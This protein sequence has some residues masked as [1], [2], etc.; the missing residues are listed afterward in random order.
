MRKV[1]I[2]IS[3]LM[4]SSMLPLSFENVDSIGPRQPAGIL[5]YVVWAGNGTGIPNLPVTLTNLNT[6]EYA[7]TTTNATGFFIS[8]LFAYDGENFYGNATYEGTTGD[9]TITVDLTLTSQWMNIS[10]NVSNGQTPVCFWTYTPHEPCAGDTVSFTDSSSDPDG[11]IV[12]WYWNFG[13]GEHGFSKHTTHSFSEVGS[14]YVTLTV[15]DNDGNTAWKR[16]Q[17]DVIDCGGPPDGDE[18]DEDIIFI[19]PIP[20][21]LYPNRPYTVPDMYHML[22]IDRMHNGKGVK[23]AVIDTGVAF[24]T[25]DKINLSEV[26][27][28]AHPSMP[29]INDNVGHGTWCN[30]AV[31]YGLQNLT[32]RGTQYSIKIIDENTCDVSVL[33][34]ALSLAKRLDVDVISISLGGRGGTISDVVSSKILEMRKAGIIVVCAAGND[35]P[36]SG[37][38]NTPGISG[39]AITVGSVD[40]QFTLDI[41]GDD[42]ISPWSSRGPVAG[43]GECKPDCVAGG[44]SI[45]GPYGNTERVVS[46]TSMATPCIAGGVAVVYSQHEFLYD[47]LKTLYFPYKQIVPNIFEKGLEK[48]CY[49]KGDPYAY[50]YGIPNFEKMS[51]YCSWM[52]FLF[53]ILW[54]IIVSIIV[55]IVTLVIYK[56]IKNKNP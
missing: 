14:Y 51:G 18:D 44:E 9:V 35:G 42:T 43:L 17:I 16:K 5:G 47:T 28:Y 56:K 49:D 21:P 22:K 7:N 37:T 12:W 55:V 25:Y 20:E 54:I 36:I 50:G 13:D 45:I 30:Y 29:T 40:P 32:S 27:A 19:P 34:D 53:T 24:V 48:H 31:A 46:G 15:T 1:A 10:I 52:A 6:G 33:I 41:L 2:L 26:R 8:S 4:L 23:V 3:V 11:S 39:S 38:I